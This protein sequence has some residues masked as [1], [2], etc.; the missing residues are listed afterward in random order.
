MTTAVVCIGNVCAG[1]CC[2]VVTLFYVS[3]TMCGVVVELPQTPE[4]DLR[5]ARAACG[6]RMSKLQLVH[7]CS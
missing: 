3:C 4:D 6:R 1:C 2:C 7:V 5:S